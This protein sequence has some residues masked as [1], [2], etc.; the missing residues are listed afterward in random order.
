MLN[1]TD[2][3]RKFRALVLFPVLPNL[4][5]LVKQH[6][7]CGVGIPLLVVLMVGTR[8]KAQSEL[9]VTVH[10]V[11]FDEG[12]WDIGFQAEEG[13][14]Y[15]IQTS[16]QLQEGIW[17]TARIHESVI[18][19]L[20]R[21]K[22]PFLDLNTNREFLRVNTSESALAAIGLNEAQFHDLGMD[23]NESLNGAANDQTALVE[24]DEYDVGKWLFTPDVDGIALFGSQ[25]VVGETALPAVLAYR[26]LQGLTPGKNYWVGVAYLWGEG[27]GPG[28]F[29]CGFSGRKGFNVFGDSLMDIFDD[30]KPRSFVNLGVHPANGLQQV[31]GE[32]GHMTADENGRIRVFFAPTHDGRT[33]AIDG[34]ISADPTHWRPNHDVVYASADLTHSWFCHETTAQMPD[35]SVMVSGVD[36]QGWRVLE[37]FMPQSFARNKITFKGRGESLLIDDHDP[38]ALLQLPD[39]RFLVAYTHHGKEDFVRIWRSTNSNPT[40]IHDFEELENAAT[41]SGVSYAG[42]FYLAQEGKIHLY[43]RGLLSGRLVFGYMTSEDFGETWSEFR[44]IMING[45]STTSPFPGDRYYPRWAGDGVSKIHWCCNFGSPGYGGPD[46]MFH[47][48]Y[49]N[50]AWW[51]SGGTLISLDEDLPFDGSYGNPRPTEVFDGLPNDSTIGQGLDSGIPGAG[52]WIQDAALD[53]Q[54]NPVFVWAAVDLT[55]PTYFQNRPDSNAS[56]R[57]ESSSWRMSDRHYYYYSRWNGSAWVTHFLAQGGTGIN[58]YGLGS[59]L[60]SPSYSGGAAISDRDPSI[61][62]ISSNSANIG[63]KTSREVEIYRQLNHTIFRASTKDGGESWTYKQLVDRDEL[64]CRPRYDVGSGALFYQS[65]K[66]DNFVHYTCKEAFAGID[67]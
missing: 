18:A 48:Y 62:Y 5:V 56:S 21:E 52:Y 23:P 36:S 63:E 2:L 11:D 14:Y 17:S 33:S 22:I 12:L 15:A 66:F 67:P 42:L 10:Q 47:F 7:I 9:D 53:H 40:S 57:D 61:V 4:I 37:R 51:Q 54:G 24:Q 20:V 34:L 55:T 65:G 30:S 58:N 28:A 49:E 64:R 29:R 13:K 44:V 59:L 45:Y 25:G 1:Y 31:I 19:Q 38:P 50:E 41:P 6:C 46:G 60:N 39:G 26:D 32:L 35:G 8:A 16:D 27:T 3:F 43:T